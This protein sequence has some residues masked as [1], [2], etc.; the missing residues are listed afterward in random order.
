MTPSQSPGLLMMEPSVAALKLVLDDLGLPFDISRVTK[1]K[2]IQKA[3]HIARPWLPRTTSWPK[4]WHWVR[5]LTV[6]CGA[7]CEKGS[8]RFVL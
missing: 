5:Q 1:R 7:I 8:D 4:R 2:A 6:S 3:A